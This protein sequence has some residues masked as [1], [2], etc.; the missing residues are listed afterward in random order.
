MSFEPP[1]ICEFAGHEWEDAGG[2]V[3]ICAEC[4]TTRDASVTKV[5]CLMC[6]AKGHPANMCVVA[7]S[8]DGGCAEYYC[9]ECRWGL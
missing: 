6:G 2:N 5:S 1:T 3:E 7:E 9:Q 4:E 8:V